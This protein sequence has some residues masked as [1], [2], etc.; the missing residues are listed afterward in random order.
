[1][2]QVSLFI[3]CV[4][5]IIF[6]C[7]SNNLNGLYLVEKYYIYIYIDYRYYITNMSIVNDNSCI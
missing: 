1:M 4:L 2:S 5:H 6:L 3:I 7:K